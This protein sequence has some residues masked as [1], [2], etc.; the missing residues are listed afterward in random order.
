MRFYQVS[1]GLTEN[2]GELVK[3]RGKVLDWLAKI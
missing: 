3:L 1:T 2:I